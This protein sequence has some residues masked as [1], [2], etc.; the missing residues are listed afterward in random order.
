MRRNLLFFLGCALLAVWCSFWLFLTYPKHLNKKTPKLSQRFMSDPNKEMMILFYDFPSYYELASLPSLNCKQKCKFSIQ[1][2]LSQSAD[3]IV[4]FTHDHIL[5]RTKL[6]LVK[7]PGQTWIFFA[8][9]SPPYSNQNSLRGKSFDW[10]MTYRLDSDIFFGY[11]KTSKRATPAS[12]SE[13]KTDIERMK[14]SFR[15][16][17]KM[18]AWMVSHCNTESRREKYVEELK[19][20]IQVDVYGGCGT[21][22][23]GNWSFCDQMVGRDYKFYL[24]F[25]N[26]LCKDYASEKL[27]KILQKRDTVP[28]VR[29]GADYK[30]VCPPDSVINTAD[31]SSAA[32]LANFLKTLANKEEAYTN[33]LKWGWEYE[34]SQPKLPFCELCEKLHEAP[35]DREPYTDAVKWWNDGTCHRPQDL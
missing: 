14:E 8:V 33:M 4:V 32:E 19:R 10:T 15:K 20:H 34:V 3:A 18:V 24:S 25:E 21:L 12:A 1:S 31:F 16:K 29:G 22:K 27:L 28:I 30:T 26:T 13:R 23:C 11:I 9:E 5:G 17:T 35:M 6:D 7:R 2:N